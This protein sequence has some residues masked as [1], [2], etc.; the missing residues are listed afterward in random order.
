MVTVWSRGNNQHNIEYWHVLDSLSLPFQIYSSLFSILLGGLKRL[1]FN[2]C[3]NGSFPL[4]FLINFKQWEE[5]LGDSFI[6]PAISLPDWS[7]QLVCPFTEA[8]FLS[9]NSL[10]C[11][12]FCT[13]SHPCPSGPVIFLTLI[14]PEELHHALLNSLMLAYTFVD[15]SLIYPTEVHHLLSMK[16]LIQW[17]SV[18]LGDIW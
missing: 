14:S 9:G 18:P 7:G 15:C 13:Y 17:L 10:L 8:Q 1:I 11:S 16:T 4:W 6:L 12:V 2:H 3:I 5:P